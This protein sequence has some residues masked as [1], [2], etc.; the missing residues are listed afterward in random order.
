[1]ALKEK[2]LENKR[3]NEENQFKVAE[4]QSKLSYQLGYADSE[5]RDVTIINY[6]IRL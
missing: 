4:Q 5:N 1:M 2:L 3:L 6:T